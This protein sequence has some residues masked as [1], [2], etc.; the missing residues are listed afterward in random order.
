MAL[1]KKRDLSSADRK[2]GLEGGRGVQKREIDRREG[3][4][5]GRER[6]EDLISLK[7]TN[8]FLVGQI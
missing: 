8:F 4:R 1:G 7:T 2:V 3:R 5:K 6:G